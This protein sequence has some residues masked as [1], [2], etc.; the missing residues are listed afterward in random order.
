M[1]IS[2][3]KKVRGLP[4]IKKPE[5]AMITQCQ[6]GRMTKSSFKR[7]TYTSSNI[8]E[9][10]PADLY[11]PID[12]EIYCGDNYYNVFFDDYFRMMN[13]IFIKHKSNAL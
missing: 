4:K 12:V 6:L 11:G 10:V 2:K 3:I 1:K 5:N 9:L 13:V 8:F 7:K